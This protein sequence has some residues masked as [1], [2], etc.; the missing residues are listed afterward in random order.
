MHVP[1]KSRDTKPELLVRKFLFSRGLRYRV[2]V[3]KLPGKPDIVLPKYKIVIFVNGCFWHGHA[4]CKY[5]TIPKSNT[6]FW[7][8]K[9]NRN[10]TRDDEVEKMLLSQG[11]HVI[12]VWECDLKPNKATN[13]LIKLYDKIIG[14]DITDTPLIAAEPPVE[15]GK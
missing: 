6:E 5:A 11:W 8:T 4:G 15:Y 2:N 12:R 3:S 9:I 7:Q 13:T 10:K 14:N 1:L